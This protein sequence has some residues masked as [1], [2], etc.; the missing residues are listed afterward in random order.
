MFTQNQNKL[1]IAERITAPTP[2]LFAIIRNIGI[3]IATIAGAIIGLEQ[4]G[5]QLPEVVKLIADKAAIIAGIVAAIVSQLTVNFSELSTKKVMDK[6][7]EAAKKKP[8]PQ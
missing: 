6:I 8:Q 4:Q 5:V 3:V 1:S 2:K 7:A